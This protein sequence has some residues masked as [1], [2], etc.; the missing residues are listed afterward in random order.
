MNLLKDD[1]TIVPIIGCQECASRTVKVVTPTGDAKNVCKTCEREP[2]R[3]CI[4][5]AVKARRQL[6]SPILANLAGLA[7]GLEMG[8]L[9]EKAE[10]YRAAIRALEQEAERA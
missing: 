5:C 4:A 6:V 1:G 2:A 3:I 10:G 9:E 8:G 7:K